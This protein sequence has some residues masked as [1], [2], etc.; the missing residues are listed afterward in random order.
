MQKQRLLA[1]PAFFRVVRS[2]VSTWIK[3]KKIEHKESFCEKEYI[4]KYLNKTMLTK[5]KP[6]YK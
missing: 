2:G 4:V 6:F 5:E 1:S 3:Y